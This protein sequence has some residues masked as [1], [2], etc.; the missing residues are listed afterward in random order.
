MRQP[1]KYK[2]LRHEI[3]QIFE[4]SRRTYGYRRI[5]C[6]LKTRGIMVS[7]KVIRRLLQE[8]NLIIKIKRKRKYNVNI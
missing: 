8:E 1:D 2:E 6:I 7:D 5:N 3:H 4:K